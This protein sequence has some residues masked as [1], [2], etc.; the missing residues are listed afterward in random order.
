MAVGA[1]IVIFSF[2]A[3]TLAGSILLQPLVARLVRGE[4]DP[5]FPVSLLLNSFTLYY[6]VLLALLSVAVFENYGKAQDAIARE[7][8]SLVALYRNVTG[9][10][11]PMRGELIGLLRR[12]VEAETAADAWRSQFTPDFKTAG[13]RVVDELNRL[14]ISVRPEGTSNDEALHNATLHR[15]DIFIE[16][17]RNRIQAAGTSIPAIIWWVVLIGAALNVFVLWLFNLGRTTH[18]IL[19][20]VLT[21]FIA[22]VVYMVATL[23]QP[24]RGANGLRPDYLRHAQERMQPL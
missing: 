7:A 20:G 11:E 17:R 8:A 19:G 4:K 21:S 2:L 13:T 23:D 12:Y 16:H 1:G 5:N 9:Y 24:F 18:L 22:L 3:P 15:F 10:P 14:L 6:G